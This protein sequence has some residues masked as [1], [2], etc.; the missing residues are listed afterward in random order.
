MPSTQTL[1][2]AERYV[3]S[4]P[5]DEVTQKVCSLFLPHESAVNMWIARITQEK[6]CMYLSGL[7]F[8]QINVLVLCGIWPHSATKSA[9]FQHTMHHTRQV[10]EEIARIDV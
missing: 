6:K 5:K 4:L 8:C 3:A 10:V 9:A 1:T 7:F 2:Q